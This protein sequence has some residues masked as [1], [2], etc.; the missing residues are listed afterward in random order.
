MPKGLPDSVIYTAV[1]RSTKK[2]KSK[3][4]DHAYYEQNAEILNAFVARLF[5]FAKKGKN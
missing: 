2:R 3:T 1:K 4:K 5:G